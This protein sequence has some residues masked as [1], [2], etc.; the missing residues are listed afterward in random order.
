MYII[1][2]SIVAICILVL[3]SV[4]PE[5]TLY[6]GREGPLPYRSL[7]VSQGPV[8][9]LLILE[10]QPLVFCSGTFSCASVFKAIALLLDLVYLVLYVEAS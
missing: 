4:S 6:K 7:S 10:P 1:S 2:L 5:G 8:Y 3:P 9:Q